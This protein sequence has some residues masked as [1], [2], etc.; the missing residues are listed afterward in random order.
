M[1]ILYNKKGSFKAMASMMLETEKQ[2]WENM[3]KISTNLT[4]DATS[5]LFFLLSIHP[6]EQC[7]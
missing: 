5:E 7:Q 2:T 3:E 6:V 4:K 1:N